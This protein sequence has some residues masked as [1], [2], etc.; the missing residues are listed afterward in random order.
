MQAQRR[1]IKLDKHDVFC[2]RR[3]WI[4]NERLRELYQNVTQNQERFGWTINHLLEC[5]DAV[6]QLMAEVERLTSEIEI[7]RP[8]AN[9]AFW[10]VLLLERDDVQGRK[11]LERMIAYYAEHDG[12][13]DD[14]GRLRIVIDAVAALGQED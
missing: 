10:A 6:S 8:Q 2:A 5:D 13:A 4:E 11:V 3:L 1:P 7:L 9:P 12:I 14:M